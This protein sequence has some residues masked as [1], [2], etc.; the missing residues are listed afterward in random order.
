MKTRLYL[1]LAGSLLVGIASA[2][3]KELGRFFPAAAV[4]TGGSAN[5]NYLIGGYVSPMAED[6]GSL[7][8]NGWYHTA[9]NHKRFGFD[10]NV[11]VSSIFISGGSNYFTVDNSQ[12]NGVG[13]LGTTAGTAPMPTAYGPESELPMFTINS[14]PNAG[15]TFNGPGGGNISKE[16]PIGSLMVPTIQGGLG[17]FANTDLRFRFTPAI[18]L[19]N[20]EM[21]NWGV[22]LLHDVKQ[23]IAGMKELPFSLSLLL[24]Y[25]NM[26]TKTSLGGLYETSLN[27]GSYA[28]QEATAETTAFTAQVLISKSIPVLTFYGGIGYNS[29]ST[30]FA[31]KGNYFVDRSFTALGEVPLLAPISLTDPYKN[32][33]SANGFRFTGGIRFKFGPMFLNGDYTF[34]GGEGLLSTGLGLTVR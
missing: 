16:I 7:L 10:L 30:S 23:H 21:Q 12:L 24:A 34:F 27:S 5:L 17:L 32:E 14:G 22:G 29:S 1:I 8:N 18:S 20:T 9:E 26:T 6:F 28:G 33:F 11:T 3:P 31:V 25:S 15:Q 4:G 2:Q 13:Y 19:N